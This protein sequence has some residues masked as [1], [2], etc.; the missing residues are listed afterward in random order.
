MDQQAAINRTAT[1]TEIVKDKAFKTRFM[2]LFL[3]NKSMPMLIKNYL[4]G[5]D[6]KFDN[7]LIFYSARRKRSFI[8][9]L[10]ESAFFLNTSEDTF[11]LLNTQ[12]PL[13]SYSY[14]A[15]P[16]Q[17]FTIVKNNV[18]QR[19]DIYEDRT[20]LV[21][22][23]LKLDMISIFVHGIESVNKFLEMITHTRT[24]ECRFFFDKMCIFV[25]ISGN[26]YII[27]T[28]PAK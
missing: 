21:N 5:D 26:K 13:V 22:P 1:F 20:P 18:S 15:K 11:M 24:N 12:Y 27:E 14:S 10:P 7:L 6:W 19:Y 25:K 4:S 9:D 23:V 17:K 28:Y 8:Q 3:G 2:D 16:E